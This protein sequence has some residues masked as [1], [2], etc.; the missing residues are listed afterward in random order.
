[1]T[2][3]VFRIIRQS[4]NIRCTTKTDITR[5][6]MI[7]WY[8]QNAHW[9]HME[10]TVNTTAAPRVVYL[11]SVKKQQENAL[12]DVHPDGKDFCAS[13]VRCSIFGF[14]FTIPNYLCL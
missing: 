10:M 1:M 13:K 12:E 14:F 7:N 9:V 4:L 6:D 3:F 8:L 2:L 11:T 5:N